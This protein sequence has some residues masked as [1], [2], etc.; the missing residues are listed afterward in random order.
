MESLTAIQLIISLQYRSLHTND[1]WMKAFESYRIYSDSLKKRIY[2]S[3]Q[4][5]EPVPNEFVETSPAF[6]RLS[7]HLNIK[8]IRHH[9]KLYI[10]Y[11][12]TSLY[13]FTLSNIR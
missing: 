5:L 3:S 9:K 11:W 2:R 6:Q 8:G 4:L 12:T 1:R 7:S 13:F 10:S